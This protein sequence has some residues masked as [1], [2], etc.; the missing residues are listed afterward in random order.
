MKN[1][2]SHRLLAKTK[3]IVVICMG[4][5]VLSLSLK[6]PKRITSPPNCTVI[7]NI[8]KSYYNKQ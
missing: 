6:L 8:K 1:G 4:P 3:I 7:E 2:P 5:A